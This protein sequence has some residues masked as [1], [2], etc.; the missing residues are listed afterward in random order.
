MK[1]FLVGMPSCGKSSLAKIIGK[2]INIQFIDLDKEIEIVEKRSINEIF[3]IKGEGYFRKIESEVLN[4]IIKSNKSF[5][6]ATGGGT[7]CYNDNMK[8]INNN[9]ISIFLDVK[10][11]ELE[12]RLKNKK[13]RPL[14]NRYQDKGKILKKIYDERKSYYHES[15]YTISDIK[16]QKTEILSI[17]LQLK[18]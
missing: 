16:D 8:I 10:I 2:E 12:T 17:I 11:S 4:S 9:G 7:P 18:S 5:I 14:L 1:Y 13:D 15:N 3:N 6:M